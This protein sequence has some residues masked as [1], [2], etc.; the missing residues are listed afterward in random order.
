MGNTGEISDIQREK[1]IWHI[2]L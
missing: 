2:L 1:R